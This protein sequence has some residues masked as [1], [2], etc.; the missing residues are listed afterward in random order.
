M[1]VLGCSLKNIGEMFLMEAAFIGA[2]GGL[3]GN[4]LSFIMSLAINALTSQ[5]NMLG[6]GDMNISYIP[7]WLVLA[8]VGFAMLVGIAAGFFPARRAMRLSPL[9]AIRNN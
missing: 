6:S 4:V 5:A 7:V 3:I 8:S 2:V 9:E 1:K